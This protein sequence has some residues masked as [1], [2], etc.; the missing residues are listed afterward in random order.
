MSTNRYSSD[1]SRRS[2]HRRSRGGFKE[3]SLRSH[4]LAIAFASLCLFSVTV[5][6]GWKLDSRRGVFGDGASVASRDEAVR[7]SLGSKHPAEGAFTDG[8]RAAVATVE[9]LSGVRG[10]GPFSLQAWL[11]SEPVLLDGQN[12]SSLFTQE[13]TLRTS[14][15]PDYTLS[16]V[17]FSPRWTR[18]DGFLELGIGGSRNGAVLLRFSA[19]GVE[20]FFVSRSGIRVPIQQGSGEQRKRCGHYDVV[21]QEQS[22][23]ISCDSSVQREIPAVFSAKGVLFATS[24]LL[25]GDLADLVVVGRVGGSEVEDRG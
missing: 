13:F 25:Q 17:S 2:T 1:R 9:Q 15:R 7:A 12:V 4:P 5:F 22:L 3:P 24:N 6:V 16:R 23:N 20:P 10:A 8:Y 18:P 14:L 21:V 19:D 11:P